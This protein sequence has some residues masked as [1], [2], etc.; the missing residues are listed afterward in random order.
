MPEN[1]KKLEWPESLGV[2]IHEVLRYGFGGLL[3]YGVA[4]VSAPA[5]TK[6]ALESLGTVIS[7]SL[8][9]ALGAAIYAAYRPILGELLAYI[10]EWIH[11]HV[12]LKRENASA[13]CRSAYFIDEWEDAH[14][15]IPAAAEAFRTVR[16]SKAFDQEKQKRFY[17]QHSELVMPY[18]A[19]FVLTIGSLIL[20]Y[21]GPG[22]ALVSPVLMF[23]V[24]FF[25]LVCGFVGDILLCRQECKVLWQIEKKDITE[26]L[27][28]TK[29]L[30][31]N[32]GEGG[33]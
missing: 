5:E 22:G 9:F 25:F 24:G 26:I 6:A 33:Q 17:L 13:N 7:V 4:A 8:A 10:R 32:E 23:A 31:P 11:M 27:T 1:G 3:L 19:F 2:T 15:K 21:K 18:I 30:D 28:K 29:F 14:F 20:W 12:W 16:D